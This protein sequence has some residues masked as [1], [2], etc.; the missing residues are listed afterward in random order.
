MPLGSLENGV[1]ENQ[2]SIKRE[3]LRRKK[4]PLL[5]LGLEKSIGRVESGF[6]VVRY[7]FLQRAVRKKGK[8]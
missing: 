5:K 8:Y 2:A 7:V 3:L 6:S 1:N 4:A